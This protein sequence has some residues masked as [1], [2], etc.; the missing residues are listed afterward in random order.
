MRLVAKSP[1][2]YRSK[3]YKIGEQL[4][5]DNQAMVDAWL[6]AESAEWIDE[7]KD[8]PEKIEPKSNQH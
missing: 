1:I 4:P 2:L 6:E 8:A 3:Q 7:T 5:A